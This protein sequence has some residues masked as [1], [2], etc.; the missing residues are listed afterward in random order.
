M[1]I[2]LILSIIVS[3]S[4][5]CAGAV[6]KDK[7]FSFFNSTFYMKVIDQEGLPVEGVEV[8]IRHGSNHWIGGGNIASE[9]GVSD[10][11]GVITIKV[12]G[13]QITLK[14]MQKDNYYILLPDIL[15]EY[16]KTRSSGV[17]AQGDLWPADFERFSQSNPFIITAWRVDPKEKKATCKNGFIRKIKLNPDGRS[18]GIDILQSAS[19]QV[20]KE[21]TPDRNLQITMKREKIKPSSKLPS[22]KFEIFKKRWQFEIIMMN[23][24]LIEINP[25]ELY[26]KIPPKFGYLNSWKLD[27][28]TFKS[29]NN[30]YSG[31]QYQDQRHF[32]LKINDN[33][34]ARLSINFAPIGMHLN[35][36]ENGE[37]TID[38][39]VD[40][41]AVGYVR[42]FNSQSGRPRLSHKNTCVNSQK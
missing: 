29:R 20:V 5:V 25:K 6:P 1:K 7:L 23:G 26:Q 4:T 33:Q 2:I 35:E 39:S 10:A 32:F 31:A 11:N 12:D 34:Y 15:F 41:N 16:Y 19:R 8:D 37:I 18:Y 13:R 27:N 22:I 24:G 21:N 9:K 42:S 28:D 3:S 17:P 40:V 14:R 36:I 30:A 38:Y